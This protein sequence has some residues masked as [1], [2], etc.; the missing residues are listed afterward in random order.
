MPRRFQAAQHRILTYDRQ[1][2]IATWEGQPI[3]ANNPIPD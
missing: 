1:T 3:G 2:G